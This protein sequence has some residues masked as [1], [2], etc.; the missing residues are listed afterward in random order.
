MADDPYEILGVPRGATDDQIRRAYLKL[1][2]ELHPDVN[3][4][5]TAEERFKKVTAAHDIVGD[6]DRRRQFDAG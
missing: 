5:K 4:S 1:V 3:P 2:K 6:P